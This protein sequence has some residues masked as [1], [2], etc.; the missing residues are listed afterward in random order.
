MSA[1]GK[2]LLNIAEVTYKSGHK[3]LIV[4][5]VNKWGSLLLVYFQ[6]LIFTSI[7][8]KVIFPI[9]DFRNKSH[10][11]EG[12]SVSVMDC[13]CIDLVAVGRGLCWSG[14]GVAHD[15]ADKIL[16]GKN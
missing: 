9:S 11:G 10:H 1:S 7:V 2:K 16:T 14:A 8:L 15:E 4:I 5:S 6:E 3:F 13:Q 12:V